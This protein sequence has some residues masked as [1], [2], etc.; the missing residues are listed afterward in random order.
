MLEEMLDG[1]RPTNPGRGRPGQLHR[2]PRRGRRGAR[3]RD[4]L[5]RRGAGM[6]SLALLAAASERCAGRSPPRC[7][8]AMARFS[9]RSS[10]AQAAEPLGELLNLAPDEAARTIKAPLVARIG[11]GGAGRG[12]RHAARRARPGPRR[13]IAL[14]LPEALRSLD[15]AAA[16]CPRARRQGQGRLMASPAP[17]HDLPDRA[18]HVRR[19]RSGDGRSW[20]RRS[21]TRFGEAWTRSQC[22]GI[23][24]MAGVSLSLARDGDGSGVVG[25]SLAADG[26]RRSRIAADRGRARAPPARGRPQL[27]R[28]F[29]RPGTRRWRVQRFISR[30]ATAIRRSPCIAPPASLR[31]AGGATITGAAMAAATTR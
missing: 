31:S 30:C 1:R 23:L 28:R 10:T 18:R 15:P 11:R 19:P 26:R 6:S 24:P 3:P 29:P 4:R 22:S 21:A 20:K 17:Q 16:L 27:A 25:F 14:A 9:C 13:A 2:H 12:A 5:G 7:S 8:A